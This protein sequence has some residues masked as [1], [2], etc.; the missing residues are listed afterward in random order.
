MISL[1]SLL[2]IPELKWSRN[3]FIPFLALDPFPSKT[4][5]QDDEE[6]IQVQEFTLAQWHQMMVEGKVMPTAVQTSIMAVD[7]LK[8]KDFIT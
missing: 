8:K 7:W 2:G 5:G 6:W 1:S 4:R 3:R